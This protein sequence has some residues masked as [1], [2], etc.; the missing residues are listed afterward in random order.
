MTHWYT[1]DI[2]FGHECALQLCNR[3]FET[4]AEMDGVLLD[5]PA[6]WVIA[7]GNDRDRGSYE[8]TNTLPPHN[9]RCG[10]VAQVT[11]MSA[12]RV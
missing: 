12:Q 6:M 11:S 1:A 8:Q 5:N 10:S 3:P 2:H 7:A 9:E 4:A